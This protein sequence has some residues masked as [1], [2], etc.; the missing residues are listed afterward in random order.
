[1]GGGSNS[2]G[3]LLDSAPRPQA[4]LHAQRRA[5]GLSGLPLIGRYSSAMTFG[6]LSIGLP[7]PLKARPMRSCEIGI[8]MVSPVNST[9]QSR[10]SMP[11][12]PSKTY[13]VCKHAEKNFPK[14]TERIKLL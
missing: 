7:Q 12:V 13:S 10:L 2:E 5:F 8:F 6:P 3:K 14:H 11:L 9:W 1:M 4:S